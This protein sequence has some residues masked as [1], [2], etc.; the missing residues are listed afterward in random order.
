M[1]V[2]LKAAEAQRKGAIG[3]VAIHPVERMF[4]RSLE[5]ECEEFIE[6]HNSIAIALEELG[7]PAKDPAAL[8]D[9]ALGPL[10]LRT[11]RC[12]DCCLDVRRFRAR[13]LREHRARRRRELLEGGAVCGWPLLASD[14]IAN[15]DRH[16]LKPPS[17]RSS[18]P[19]T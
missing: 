6:V 5:P 13:D 3:I 2:K 7:D 4:E 17:T 9:G 10:G 11:R 16:A 8:L 19:V 12:P 15:V 18:C 14:H 1:G